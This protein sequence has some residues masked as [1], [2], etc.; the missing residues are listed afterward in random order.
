MCE[1]VFGIKQDT[2][3]ANIANTNSFYGADRPQGS[4]ILFVNGQI[5]R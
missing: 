4:R 3:D 1:A 5:G 2:V